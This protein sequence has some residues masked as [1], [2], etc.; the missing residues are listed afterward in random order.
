MRITADPRILAKYPFAYL[1]GAEDI[2]RA[3][4]KHRIDVIH[5]HHP[6]TALYALRASRDL[7]V[8]IVLH[9]HETLPAARLYA[10]A[11][12]FVVGR[13]AKI[14]CVSQAAQKLALAMGADIARTSVVYNGVDARFLSPGA[15]RTRPPEVQKVG[16]GPHVG[17][18]GV[19]E[20]RK[21]Q[22]VFLQAVASVSPIFPS[23]RFW[24]VGA[25][26]LKD[27][28]AYA[29]QLR[30]MASA[31]PIHGRVSLV[32]FQED[33]PSWLAAMDI[34]VQCSTS[35]ESFGMSLA[36]ALTLGRATIATEVGGMPEVVQ[37]EVTGLVVPSADAPALA[38]A[39]LDLLA[40]P[41]RRATLGAAGSTDARAR[42]SP[43]AFG[44]SIA[45]L[46]DAVLANA[47]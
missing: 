37:N 10:L 24:L 6:V 16:A 25:A 5:A 32:G 28:V 15:G 39:L 35:L 33:M 14:V 41:E 12:R 20:P 21:A 27:K 38:T 11:M 31:N 17:I 23:A 47:R 2:L 3:C 30:Q 8:P 34:V 4:V 7:G 26:A 19:L 42:F 43:D 13:V 44:R 1:R 46:Y 18:F 22:H 9:V 36:E 40:S 45:S 29:E